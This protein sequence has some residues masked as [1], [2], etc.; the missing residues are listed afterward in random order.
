MFVTTEDGVPYVSV[1][2]DD[3][4]VQAPY[5]SGSGSSTLVFAH[6]VTE[7]QSPVRS[8]A[9]LADSMTLN[10]GTIT[11][12][13]GPPV[14]L[15]HPG[16]TREGRDLPAAPRLTA[17][18]EKYP[19][20]HSGDGRKFVVRVLFSE[21][22]NIKARTLRDHALTVVDG[23]IDTLW[24]V[25]DDEGKKRND[26]WAIRLMP[27]SSRDLELALAAT[28]D[29]DA[30]GAICTADKRPL[31]SAISL[32]VPGP[33]HEITVADAEVDE[34]PGAELEFVVSLSEAAPYRVKVDYETEDD[35]AT[36]GLDYTAVSGQLTFERGETAKT[37]TVPVLDD[38]HDDDGETLTLRLSNPTRATIADGEAV[39]TI[40][41][42]DM[43]P[44]A[45][46]ARFGRTVAEQV[47]DSV[48]ERISATPRAGVEVKLAGQ[49]V[50]GAGNAGRDGDGEEEAMS[51][52]LRGET[53]AADAG[54]P[55]PGEDYREVTALEL[56]TGSSFRFAAA[57]DGTGGGLV[58][59]WGRG[60]SSR[61]DGREGDLVLSGEVTSALFGADWTRG[62][63]FRPGGGDASG[64]RAGSST[65]GLM[66]SHSRGEGTYRGA[67][68]GKVESTVT[69]LYPYG[70]L[71]VTDRVTAWSVIGYGTGSLA[72]TPEAA[73]DSESGDSRTLRTDLDLAMAAAGLRG[74]LLQAS[75]EGGPEVTVK[76]DALAVRTRTDALLSDDVGNLAGATGDATRLR[77]GLQGTWRGLE[78]GDGTL[79]PGLEFGVRHDGGDAETG[80]GLDAGAAFSWTHPENGLRLQLSGRG[81]L[82]H[83]SK[84]FRVRGVAGSLSWQPRPEHGRGPKLSV[85]HALGEA[86]SGGMDTLLSQRNLAGLAADDSGDPLERQSFKLH[87]GFGFPAFGGRFTSTPEIDI[88]VSDGEREYGLGW[89]LDLVKG[90]ASELGFALKA[91]RSEAADGNAGAAPKH[92]TGFHIQARW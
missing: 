48:E 16:K 74:V 83:A 53:E 8:M 4:T 31:S 18:W 84:D 11:G 39:G 12:A 17:E 89:R 3:E 69:G 37:V 25:K 81:I 2:V 28:T 85:T 29:C 61:F 86:S 26:L 22:V 5:A 43:M 79:E 21:P 78:L 49:G 91:A 82:T 20:G 75:P 9:L 40:R 77:L 92:T 68:A 38:D 47:L 71:A 57:G 67:S 7:A 62:P 60:A 59:F 15:R 13:N 66:L 55:G 19:P 30:E 1:T 32:T 10:D 87:Y 45:W 65:T 24:Q 58:S 50:G 42:R 35:T 34:G 90:G 72:L 73:T 27:T 88:G 63:G 51:S 76:T 64:F 46:L 44:S 41:N 70:R 14:M 36:A 6:T 33:A 23:D 80:F 52:W 54:R 56:L